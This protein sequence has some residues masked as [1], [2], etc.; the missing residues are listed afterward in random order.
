MLKKFTPNFIRLFKTSYNQSIKSFCTSNNIENITLLSSI[1]DKPE[2]SD[3]TTSDNTSQNINRNLPALQNFHDKNTSEIEECIQTLI[4]DL[5]K[6]NIDL[7]LIEKSY[8]L[9]RGNIYNFIVFSRNIAPYKQILENISENFFSGTMLKYIYDYINLDSMAYKQLVLLGEHLFFQ[10]SKR[11]ILSHQMSFMIVKTKSIVNEKINKVLTHVK[12][13]KKVLTD[14]FPEDRIFFYLLLL[15]YDKTKSL[16]EL[17]EMDVPDELILN[18]NHVTVVFWIC[19]TLIMKNISDDNLDLNYVI[20]SYFI[21]A[22]K[23]VGLIQNRGPK[24]KTIR[25]ILKNYFDIIEHLEIC[26][27]GEKFRLWSNKNNIAKEVAELVGVFYSLTKTYDQENFIYF[28]KVIK[29][30]EST[31]ECMSS[32]TFKQKSEY[33]IAIKE[34]M[35]LIKYNFESKFSQILEQWGLKSQATFSNFYKRYQQQEQKMASLIIPKRKVDFNIYQ[36]IQ[37]LYF[38]TKKENYILK[39]EDQLII[40]NIVL[41]SCPFT[42]N[43]QFENHLDLSEIITDKEERLKGFQVANFVSILNRMHNKKLQEC[44]ESFKRKSVIDQEKNDYLKLIEIKNINFSSE[45]QEP[46]FEK[47]QETDLE[48]NSELERKFDKYVKVNLVLL[49]V[50]E[51][52]DQDIAALLPK[53][54]QSFSCLEK[55]FLIYVTIIEELKLFD[56]KNSS[57]FKDLIDLQAKRLKRLQ[58]GLSEIL[59]DR[60]LSK[61]D[62]GALGFIVKY[63]SLNRVGTRKFMDLAK[64]SQS[65]V[66]KGRKNKLYKKFKNTKGGMIEG[67][68]NKMK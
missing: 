51:Y 65:S 61:K 44:S 63:F 52:I 46:D 1:F 19:K 21:C 6:K 66:E 3:K 5:R 37:Y 40:L 8:K 24:D 41:E 42:N 59:N 28:L 68:K 36:A 23:K 38:N 43:I 34:R 9:S 50:L 62:K 22:I 2:I 30:H 10:N 17:M 32:V 53:G 60:D 14:C 57:S 64:A 56:V 48:T 26:H 4:S 45:N 16:V 58:F 11:L 33:I 18:E 31:Q 15:Y 35:D 29:K 49:S 39:L 25:A 67:Q 27:S 12:E 7:D 54:I 47:N 20:E 55:L 13:N